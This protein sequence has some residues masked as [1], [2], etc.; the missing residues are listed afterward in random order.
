MPASPQSVVVAVAAAAVAALVSL[1]SALGLLD[2][3]LS[4]LSSLPPLLVTEA[5][6]W[7]RHVLELRTK[8]I[9][10]LVTLNLPSMPQFLDSRLFEPMPCDGEAA[11]DSTLIEPDVVE[12]I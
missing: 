7:P 5:S 1:T 2:F 4:R 6:E 8:Q 3:V 11:P 10:R 12:D 9:C